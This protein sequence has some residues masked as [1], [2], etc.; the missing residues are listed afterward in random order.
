[1]IVKNES[2]I[3]GRCLQSVE[4]V[5]GFVISDTGSTD[6][7]I[8]LILKWGKEKN[9]PGVVLRN[10][11][12]NFG[13]N[14]TQALQQAKKW[15]QEQHMDLSKTYLLFLDADM[16]F[17]GSDLRKTIGQADVWDIRQQNPTM[18]YANLRAVRASVEIECKCPTHEYYQIH[19][20]N[21]VRKLFDGANIDDIGDGG[22]KDDKAQR[23]IRMLKEALTT[24]PKNCRYWFY[25]ANTYRDVQDYHGAIL[26]YQQRIDIGGW[27]EENYC[28]HLYKGDAHYVVQQFAEAIQSWL[29][30]YNIDPKRCEAL[31]RLA[32]HFRIL[33]QHQTAMLFID[34]G[35]KLPLP[36]DRQ[37]FL[38]KPVYEYKLLYELSVCAYYVQQKQRG[39]IACL[40]LLQVPQ[41]PDVLKTSIQKNIEFYLKEE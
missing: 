40:M 6:N 2:K 36:T 32:T 10:P 5:D 29:Q 9:K 16:V 41:L 33:G 11:W 20:P 7:T 30:A 24:D 22:S 15:C 12:K 35:L 13:Y 23:D 21:I 26:A 17:F 37:L 39:K 38:E 4:W 19:T 8:E 1:M 28:A 25:L 34:K 31:A 18:V 27:F 3:I 14:R